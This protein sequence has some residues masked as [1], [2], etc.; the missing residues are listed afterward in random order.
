[1]HDYG[2]TKGTGSI[3]CQ[4]CG[5]Y[6]TPKRNE[7]VCQGCIKMKQRGYP[8]NSAWTNVNPLSMLLPKSPIGFLLGLLAL[9]AMLFAMGNMFP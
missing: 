8:L 5:L 2:L 4:V 9:L 6:F 7:K 3:V 1:M